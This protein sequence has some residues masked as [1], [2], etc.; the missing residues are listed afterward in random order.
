MGPQ[1][2]K[3]LNKNEKIRIKWSFKHNDFHVKEIVSPHNKAQLVIQTLVIHTENSLIHVKGQI[4]RKTLW[5][6]AEEE[7][8]VL[9]V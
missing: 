9:F 3:M 7:Q 8:S 5:E 1:N 2:V 6:N 4:G